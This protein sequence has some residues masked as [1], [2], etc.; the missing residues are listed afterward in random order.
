MHSL[1]EIQLKCNKQFIVDFDGGK[2]SSD[3]GLL[4]IREFLHTLGIESLLKSCFK[5]NDTALF[6]IHKDN[7]NLLQMIYQIFGTYYEDNCADDL[8]CDPVLSA[9]LGKEALASQPTLSS[10]FNRMDDD[11]LRQFDS[12]MQ[13]L[14]QKV[15]SIKMPEFVLFDI[16]TTLLPTYGKQEG[17]GFNY[18][19]QAHGCHPLLCYGGLTGDL[20]RTQ[21]RDGTDYCSKEAAAFMEPIITEYRKNYPDIQLYARGD[22]GFA[23]PELYDLFEDNDANMP[24]V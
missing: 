17:E 1:K 8:R 3:G 9:V 5:T 14:R 4:L 21:L 24:S 19:Y 15:Y 23:A 10:F 13:Q 20:I 22:S 18:H 2:L 12:I 16:D 7:E 6:R 11:T